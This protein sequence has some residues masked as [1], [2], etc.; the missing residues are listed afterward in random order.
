MPLNIA[1]NQ[2][3]VPVQEDVVTAHVVPGLT[4]SFPSAFAT[5]GCPNDIG[6]AEGSFINHRCKVVL[7]D[8]C[9]SG[10]TDTG[11]G[12]HRWGKVRRIARKSVAGECNS[13]SAKDGRVRQSIVRVVVKGGEPREDVRTVTV[14]MSSVLDEHLFIETGA[15]KDL[16]VAQVGLEH[17]CP[18]DHIRSAIFWVCRAVGTSARVAGSACDPC[19]NDFIVV[20][21]I[22]P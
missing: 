13:A 12:S 19:K 9:F 4:Y 6:D 17:L 1:R 15:I 14:G 2:F 5:E 3:C 18:D 8:G 7:Q 11:K 20:L 22:H 16:L 10:T 21:N